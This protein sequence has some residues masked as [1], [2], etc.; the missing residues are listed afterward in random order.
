MTRGKVKSLPEGKNF[1]FISTDFSQKDYFFHREDYDG[2]WGQL[3]HDFYYGNKKIFM[4]FK[5]VDAVKGMRAT[6]VRRVE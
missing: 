4:E 3:I 2:D 5:S 6:N 1:G